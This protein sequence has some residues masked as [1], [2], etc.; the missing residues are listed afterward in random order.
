MNR[1]VVLFQYVY[2]G[3]EAILEKQNGE[4]KVVDFRFTWIERG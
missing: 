1:A 4:W 2:E 3:G